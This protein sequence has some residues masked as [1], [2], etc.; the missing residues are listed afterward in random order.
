MRFP[1]EYDNHMPVVMFTPWK[2][3]FPKATIKA[4]T[5]Q[6]I[7]DG[8]T[9][10]LFLPGDYSEHISASWTE[11][12]IIG[13]AAGGGGSDMWGGASTEMQTYAKSLMGGK[14][15]ASFEGG[16]GSVSYPTDV[17]IFNNVAPIQLNFSFNMVP[18]N[19]KEADSIVQ[20]CMYFK[21]KILP[22]A[23]SIAGQPRLD[24][25]AIWDIKFLKVNGLGLETAGTY[26]EMALTSV[27]VSFPSGETSVLTYTDNNP[28][29]T[30]LNLSFQSTR[31]HRMI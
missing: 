10:S 25:P 19:K 8:D 6:K 7:G 28:V 2:Y 1:L 14:L 27:D 29:Q 31:K 22:R 5:I 23:S 24:F 12:D 20:I 18:I 11:Q 17:L 21:Q 15:G 4:E 13:G 16:T 26:Y 9:V 3:Q 30:K